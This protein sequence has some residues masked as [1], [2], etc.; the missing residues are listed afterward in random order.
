M[1]WL[2]GR[3]KAYRRYDVLNEI[4][5]CGS[6]RV[7]LA[8]GGCAPGREGLACGRCR[9][10][11]KGGSDEPC[12]VCPEG[13]T[14]QGILLLYAGLVLCGMLFFQLQKRSEVVRDK[15]EVTVELETA[16]TV[17]TELPG[18]AS[19]GLRYLQSCNTMS[20]TF[21]FELPMLNLELTKF[22]SFLSL[23]LDAALFEES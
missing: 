20:T 1:E 8:E 15:A 4:M 7:C 10:G 6:A 17:T 5:K 18:H 19:V 9:E 3:K 2:Q 23:D 13:A 21:S 12:E 22:F 16:Q 14:V 11:Y